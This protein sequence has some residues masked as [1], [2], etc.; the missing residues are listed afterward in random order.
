MIANGQFKAATREKDFKNYLRMEH[1]SKFFIQSTVYTSSM[2][3]TQLL[4]AN[5]C[6]ISLAGSHFVIE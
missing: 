6:N 1:C 5:Q 4:E 2:A 3:S